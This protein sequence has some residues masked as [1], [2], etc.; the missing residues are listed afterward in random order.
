[1]A[2]ALVVVA[3][4]GFLFYRRC[5]TSRKEMHND[6]SES[7]IGLS[8]RDPQNPDGDPTA[9]LLGVL[10]PSSS[11]PTS[12][13]RMYYDREY[14]FRRLAASPLA[15]PH[16]LM[17][18]PQGEQQH[19]STTGD[20]V[21]FV[22]SNSGFHD[23]RPPSLISPRSPHMVNHAIAAQS[24]W[25][26]DD[27]DNGNSDKHEGDK[28]AQRQPPLPSPQN[29]QTRSIDGQDGPPR[30]PQWQQSLPPVVFLDQSQYLERSQ[31]LA[32][33]ME[34]IKAEKEVLDR[35]KLVQDVLVA[36]L[37]ANY[38]VSPSDPHK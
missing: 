9:E 1:M 20:E 29:L 10:L 31:E 26:S 23:Q 22:R 35:R 12:S 2:G 33:M 8:L 16:S 38:H 13:L 18:E 21:E 5:I 11:S 28:S 6:R 36:Q 30:A 7:A 37:R 3:I 14:F 32:W 34:V 27:D 24:G 4:I 25:P 15:G 17:R 19:R